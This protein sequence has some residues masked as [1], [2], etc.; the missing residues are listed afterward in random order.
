MTGM[1][2]V[3]TGGI[4][5]A[6]VTDMCTCILGPPDMIIMG[7]PTVLVGGLMAARIGDP[8]VHG[9]MIVVGLPTVLI[10][11]SGAGGGGG[12]GGGTGDGDVAISLAT[13]EPGLE[14]PL[15]QAKALADA[16]I[17]ATPFIERCMPAVPEITS[18]LPDMDA[19]ADQ[20]NTL[21]AA[22]RNATPF[23]VPCAISAVGQMAQA[24]GALGL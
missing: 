6:R 23:C 12:G 19:A 20:A 24:V 15:H 17:N 8:T 3:L 16:A 22:A 5:Q 7:S 13:S 2:T 14:S 18:V 10:G 4:P 21:I 11:E 1:P 9:G